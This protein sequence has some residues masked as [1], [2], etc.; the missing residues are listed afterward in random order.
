M[1]KPVSSTDTL[2]HV[3]FAGRPAAAAARHVTGPN[4]PLPPVLPFAASS[5]ELPGAFA[6][7]VFQRA[8]LSVESYRGEPLRRRLAAC[9]RALHAHTEAQARRILEARP[10]LLPAAVSALLIG[11]T[12]FFR[13]APVYETLRAE[14]LPKLA[15][16][17][18]PL[19][20]WSAAC[21]SGAELYSLAILL[22]EA[23][24]LEDSFL[25]GSDCRQDAIEEAAAALYNSNDM[26]KIAAP[27]RR[28]YFE[29]A[30]GAWRPVE[31]LRRRAHWKVADLGRCIEQGPWDMILWR[32]MGIYLK[33]DAAASVWQRLVSVLAT[34]GVLVAGRAERPP[35]E[36]PLTYVGRCIYR[37]CSRGSGPR[38]R[39]AGRRSLMVLENS[40]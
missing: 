39:P 10:D 14:A 34:G 4:P 37:A 19:R 5:S 30:G 21:S 18:R 35:A 29:E 8:G 36:L 12:E 22:A 33:A 23:G 1:N 9:L 38:A 28:K 7:W 31:P 20:V 26:G 6:S 3:K 25:L 40:Q 27:V 2:R 24:L 32:N 17:R 13:D 16:R 15:R 11:T